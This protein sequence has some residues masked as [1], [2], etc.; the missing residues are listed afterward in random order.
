MNFGIRALPLFLR[1]GA[2]NMNRWNQRRNTLSNGGFSHR[3]ASSDYL[4]AYDVTADGER[5][6]VARLLEGYGNRVQYSVFTC[7]LTRRKLEELLR[8]LEKLD[9]QT[10]FV[11]AYPL[12]AR[13]N[14][15]TVGAKAPSTV[16]DEPYAF[17]VS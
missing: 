4:I 10:G 14:V 11:A 2:I 16:A 15:R 9:L 1:V 17:V 3:A 6:R 13:G 5:R 12:A 7:R 8:R